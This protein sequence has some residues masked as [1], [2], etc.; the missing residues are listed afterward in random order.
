M[1]LPIITDPNP[2]LHQESRLLS[3]EEIKSDKIQN[4]IRQMIPTMYLKDGVGLAAPQVGQSIQIFVLHKNHITEP[5]L[6]SNDALVIINPNWKPT[7]RWKEWNE[8][9]CLSIPYTYGQ[10]K[11]YKK[12]TIEAL[13][14]NGNPIKFDATNFFAHIIQHE[15][16]H[17]HGILFT[18]KAKNI[19]L[20]DNK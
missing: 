3:I 18:E 12:I 16:D 1:L 4:L 8:E 14:R 19:R 13:D 2:I 9:G 11:R 6:A 17:L 7:S 10:V 20:V 15:T 5:S